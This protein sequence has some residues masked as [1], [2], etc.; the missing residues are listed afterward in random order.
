M[1]ADIVGAHWDALDFMLSQID[2]LSQSVGVKVAAMSTQAAM[3][4]GQSIVGDFSTKL[5]GIMKKS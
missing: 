3:Q 1:P 2:I 5:S 4:K